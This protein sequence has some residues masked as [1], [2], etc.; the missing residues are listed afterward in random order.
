MQSKQLCTIFL[1]ATRGPTGLRAGKYVMLVPNAIAD[2]NV[3]KLDILPPTTN[4]ILPP[5]IKEAK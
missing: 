5:Q 1:G 2:E 4:D 3:C